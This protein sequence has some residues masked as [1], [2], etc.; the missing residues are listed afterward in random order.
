MRSSQI[1]Q[2]REEG[3]KC[4]LQIVGGGKEAGL[5]PGGSPERSFWVGEG[6]KPPFSTVR[7]EE[8]RKKL[9]EE[10]VPVAGGEAYVVLR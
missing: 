2:Q 8:R 7:G 1:L 6:K 10:D 5:L 3:K 4:V 9:S